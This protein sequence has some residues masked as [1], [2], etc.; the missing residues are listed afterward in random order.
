M[1]LTP[2]SSHKKLKSWTLFDF[3]IFQFI[4]KVFF[5]KLCLPN[6]NCEFYVFPM[7]KRTIY[8]VCFC[9][10]VPLIKNLTTCIQVWLYHNTQFHSLFQK[11]L[12]SLCMPMAFQYALV[13][14]IFTLLLLF[15][16]WCPCFPERQLF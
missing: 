8:T 12:I 16:L 7:F 14:F 2:K 1:M 3:H 4:F 15:P 11:S 10:L 13:Y 9:Q 6:F 5:T